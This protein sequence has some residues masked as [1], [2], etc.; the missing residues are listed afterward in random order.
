[1][2]IQTHPEGPKAKMNPKISKSTQPT[3]S[4]KVELKLPPPP[5]QE[6]KEKKMPTRL[7]G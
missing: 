4:K 3:C 6:K 5:S 1:M 2:S 7:M